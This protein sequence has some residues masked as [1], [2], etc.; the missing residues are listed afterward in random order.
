MIIHK[1]L[2]ETEEEILS[3]TA[4]DELYELCKDY[5][6]LSNVE[7]DAMA[8]KQFERLKIMSIDTRIE[9]E[10]K[11][12]IFDVIDEFAALKNCIDKKELTNQ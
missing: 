5:L 10:P 11:W 1:L 6:N 7:S 4:K 2:A 9:K 3:V 8:P 12:N